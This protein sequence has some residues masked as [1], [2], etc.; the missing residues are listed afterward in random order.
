M[1]NIR[2]TLV[3][4]AASAFFPLALSSVG[5]ATAQAYPT[6]PIRILVPLSVGSQTDIVAR[7]IAQKMNDHWGQPVIVDNRPG[8][9]GGIAGGILVKSAPDGHTLMIYSDG[10]AVNAALNA[11]KLPFDTLRDIT[12]VSLVASFP[13]ILV[14]G[15]SLGVKTMKDLI[16][17]AKARPG[18]FSFGSAG[19]GGGIHFS[20]EMFKM[21]AG[22]DAV[23]V[24]FKGMPEALAETLAG[25]IQY[26]F[27]S[28]GPALGLIR[29]GRLLALAVASPQRS[30]ILPQVPTAAEAGLPG[31]EYE[32]WQ[33]LFAPAGT[34]RHVV[35]RLN[36]E[37][38][39]VM[40]LADVRDTLL[41]QAVVHR[42]NSPE[43][44]ERFVRNE[45]D[46]LRN[47]IRVAG[48]KSH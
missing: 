35:T 34:P 14:V 29:D 39:R 41:K 6:R 3:N 20:G 5:D 13:S 19:I 38:T 23:H 44:F 43:E 47:V 10:H 31:F 40:G 8:A 42:P 17:L 32:L 28:P 2:W 24:P 36:Q 22:L 48:I 18:K 33:G 37:V 15:P 12:R 45:I 25:R 7:L 9:A 30:P 26:T 4:L 16:A 27:T 21:A 46:K 11:D 1:R